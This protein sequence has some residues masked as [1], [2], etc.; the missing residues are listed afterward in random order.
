M[1]KPAQLQL[2]IMFLYFLAV[3]GG[4][5]CGVRFVV[6]EEEWHGKGWGGVGRGGGG[7]G[8]VRVGKFLI[9]Q[10]GEAETCVERSFLKSFSPR[11]GGRR[12]HF[13]QILAGNVCELALQTSPP[14]VAW[15]EEGEL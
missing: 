12:C 15:V 10:P 7:G 4:V 11:N 1:K 3:R 2:R 14:L 5:V 13:A 6:R 9:A 8:E